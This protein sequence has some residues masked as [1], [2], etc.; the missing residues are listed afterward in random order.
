ML[1]ALGL[2]LSVYVRQLENF[3]GAIGTRLP[4]SSRSSRYFATRLCDTAGLMKGLPRSTVPMARSS[5]AREASFS[6]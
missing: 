4:A 2:L 1:A 6:R 3:A 5:S